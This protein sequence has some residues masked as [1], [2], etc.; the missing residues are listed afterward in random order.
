MPLRIVTIGVYGWDAMSFFRALVEA[1]VQVFCDV[2][3]RRGVRGSEYTFANSV[4]LQ[5]RLAGAGIRYVHLPDLA[6]SAAA[7]AGQSAADRATRTARRK[8]TVLSPA[9]VDAYRQERLAGFDSAAFIARLGIEEPRERGET[10]VVALF[11]VERDPAACHR[12]L[13]AERLAADLGAEIVHLRPEM[14]LS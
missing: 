9:F 8:R 12:S 5:E 3:A 13:L 2:R 4:R 6:P 10:Q 7:R 11:C 1:G 14:I